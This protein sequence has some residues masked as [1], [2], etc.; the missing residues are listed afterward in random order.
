MLTGCGEG[1]FFGGR[2]RPI[3]AVVKL[4]AQELLLISAWF[5]VLRFPGIVD[6]TKSVPRNP[7]HPAALS[8]GLSALMISEDRRPFIFYPSR[9]ATTHTA[10]PP[11]SAEWILIFNKK[12]TFIRR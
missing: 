11:L 4:T 1:L 7:T 12:A 10:V 2:W 6:A 9:C 5:Y 8:K 3:S